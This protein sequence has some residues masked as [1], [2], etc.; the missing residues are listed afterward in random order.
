[1]PTASPIVPD[2]DHRR[3]DQ[4]RWYGPMPAKPYAAPAMF[5]IGW[6]SMQ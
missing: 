3:R 4:Q 6:A 2:D 1:V 5:S